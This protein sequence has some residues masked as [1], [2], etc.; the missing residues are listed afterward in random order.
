MEALL[1]ALAI[2]YCIV[3]NEENIETKIA[4]IVRAAQSASHPTCL[5][6]TGEFTTFTGG[7]T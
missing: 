1:Q 3:E 5:L 6:F 4:D 2:P 7:W